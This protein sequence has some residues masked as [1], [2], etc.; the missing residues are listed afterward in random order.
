MLGAFE[1]RDLVRGAVADG[2]LP[3][4]RVALSG[5]VPEGN[6]RLEDRDPE[7]VSRFFEGVLWLGRW[8]FR[9]RVYC[10]EHVPADG[11][12]L[13]VGNHNGGL[14]AVDWALAVAAIY[15]AYG[16]SRAVYGLGHDFL[17]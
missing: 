8:Y 9:H 4:V 7:F 3:V 16:P 6:T 12:A 10:L 13:L 2:L 1:P 17:Q 11:P 15:R 14:T 5:K